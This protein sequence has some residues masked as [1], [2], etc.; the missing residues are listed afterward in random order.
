MNGQVVCISGCVWRAEQGLV[1]TLSPLPPGLPASVLL[2][3]FPRYNLIQPDP[4]QLRKPGGSYTLQPQLY[5]RSKPRY[6]LL[7]LRLNALDF[8]YKK[9]HLIVNRKYCTR[10]QNKRNYCSRIHKA[11]ILRH[12]LVMETSF[13]TRVLRMAVLWISISF[14][15]FIFSIFGESLKLKS[16]KF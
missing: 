9:R 12:G 16:S 10:M 13:K 7:K 1:L 5:N 15:F 6:I 8:N 14:N 4:I 11:Q 2:Q 3:A